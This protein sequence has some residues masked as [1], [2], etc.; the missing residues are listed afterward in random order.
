MGVPNILHPHD[1]TVRLKNWF[2]ANI[3]P[4]EL[5]LTA[6]I[7]SRRGPGVEADCSSREGTSREGTYRE[8][9]LSEGHGRHTNKIQ[10]DKAE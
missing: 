7:A 1:S 10:L 6:A 2:S 3:L 8:E 4:T 9:I 5:I